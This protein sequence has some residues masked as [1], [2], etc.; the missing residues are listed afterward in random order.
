MVLVVDDDPVNR[1]I[2]VGSLEAQGYAS[3]TACNGRDALRALKTGAYDV[4]LLDLVMPVLDGFEVLRTMKEDG[5]LRSLPVI[6]VS[7]LE[8]MENVV[9]CIE[10]GATDYLPKPFDPVLLRARL[11]SSLAAKRLNDVVA[12]HVVEIEALAEQLKLRNRFIQETFGRY[13]SDAVVAEI[14]ESPDGLRLGGEKRKVTMLMSDLRGFSAMAERLAPEQVV[15]VINNYLGTMAEVILAHDGTIDEFIGDS[16]LG[17]FGAPVA[18]ADDARRAVACALAMQKG[19][20]RVNRRNLDEGL[21]AVEMGIAVHT[22]DVV[23]GNIGSEKRAKYGAV[24]GHVNLTARIESYTCGGQVLISEKTLV[25]A[26]EGVV[27]G[28]SLSVRAKGFP[29]PVR[30]HDLLGLEET[31]S[32]HLER[33]TETLWPLDPPLR[34]VFTVLEG[35]RVGRDEEPAEIVALSRSGA[36]LRSDATIEALSDLKLRIVGAAGLLP[37]DLYA[38]AVPVPDGPAGLTHLRFTSVPVE[39]EPLIRRAGSGLDFLL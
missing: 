8:E 3:G 31:P 39:L 6:V 32:L 14:L 4:V 10:M 27:T 34:T 17:F 36:A 2:L 22:G 7:A 24:G 13:L 38:K 1:A 16:V 9:R 25:E 28:G 37:G 30:V 19:M 12:A 18:R 35:K 21:P 33:R 29:E 15:R 5:R 26:G 11:K 20:E 23:V